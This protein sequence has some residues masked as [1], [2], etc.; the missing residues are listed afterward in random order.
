MSA[1]KNAAARTSRIL[2]T[3]HFFRYCRE[4]EFN[5]LCKAFSV[6]KKTAYRDIRLLEQAG[7]L[8]ARYDPSL[9]AFVPESLDL[10]PMEPFENATQRKYAGKLRRLCRFMAELDAL[11]ET[12]NPIALYRSLFPQEHDRTRQ[13]DFAE[14]RRLGYILAYSGA[15]YGEPGGWLVQIPPAFGLDTIPEDVNW[16]GE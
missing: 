7:V 4:V 14:L 2:S 16:W 13:R 1:G 5:T 9:R 6:G 11:E 3:Y 12:G 10:R 15:A 8:L